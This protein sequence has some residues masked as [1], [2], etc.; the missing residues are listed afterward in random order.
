MK[1][2]ALIVTLLLIGFTLMA[3]EVSPAAFY[4][5]EFRPEVYAAIVERAK[6]VHPF[7]HAEVLEQIRWQSI[8]VVEFWMLE[9]THP[10]EADAALSK[11][12]DGGPAVAARE[13]A[14]GT[15][16]LTT[17]TNWFRVVWAIEDQIADQMERARVDAIQ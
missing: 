6:R 16:V 15:N 11:W 4:L 10:E 13:R 17:S 14:A 12:T 9:Q 8:S 7:D 3:R 2:I 1:K 5:R